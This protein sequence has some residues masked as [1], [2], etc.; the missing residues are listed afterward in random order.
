M[1]S[2]YDLPS[3]DLTPSIVVSTNESIW[4]SA[5]GAFL[6]AFSA[7]VFGLITF[8]F[9]KKMERFWKHKSAVVEIEH[10]LQDNLDQNS[11]NQFLLKGAIET[12]T[13]NHLTYTLLTQLRLS[14]D[15]NLRIGDLEVLNKYFDYKNPVLK[16]NHGMET[17]QG[18]NTQLQQAITANFNL[19]APVVH[20]NL[21]H[22][23]DQAQSLLKFMVSLDK[24]TEYLLAYVKVY[25]RKERHI[26]TRGVHKLIN[27]N[28]QFVTKSEIDAEIKL[29]KSE[30]AKISQESKERIEEIM[31]GQIL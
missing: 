9:Q 23:R 14:D 13:R 7:F 5:V 26:W 29:L 6:G 2:L 15:I 25:M 1:N 18:M 24:D 19:P 31:N 10:I 21:N 27:K 28:I 30:I 20:K 3:V 22:L 11:A 8:Y 16:I 12:L 17:W 4:P